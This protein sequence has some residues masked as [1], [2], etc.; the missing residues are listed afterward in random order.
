MKIFQL[1]FCV[2][3][4]IAFTETNVLAESRYRADNGYSTK[5]SV[6]IEVGGQTKRMTV[7]SPYES[8]SMDFSAIPVETDRIS[9][10]HGW[11]CLPPTEQI[12][13]ER[14]KPYLVFCTK[15]REECVQVGGYE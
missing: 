4:L 13:F 9:I 7:L 1:L 6:E 14:C 10:G 5:K 11:Q 2:A 8:R 15:D 3:M 12:P